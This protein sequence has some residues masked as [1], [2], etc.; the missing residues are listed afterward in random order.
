MN[1]EQV[2]AAGLS[3]SAYAKRIGCS[4]PYISKCVKLG[5]IPADAV[6][7]GKIDPVK[8]D[9]ALHKSPADPSTIKPKPAAKNAPKAIAARA[10]SGRKAAGSARA[11]KVP[12][13]PPND[14]VS[15]VDARTA[16]EITLGKQ[17][18]LDYRKAIGELVQM[19]DVKRGIADNCGEIVKALRR[20]ADQTAGQLA[21]ESDP[22][23][24]HALLAA[25]IDI[26]CQQIADIAGALPDRLS[27]TSQ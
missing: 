2:V 13:N 19:V 4:Q 9:A 14:G 17:A 10:D 8:A 27:A 11:G 23:A 24:V 12:P 15:Y 26:V 22:R 6:V 1:G 18:D 7:D 21:A 3:F 5:R 16:R 25:H 20:I